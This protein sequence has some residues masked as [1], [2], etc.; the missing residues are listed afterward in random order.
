MAEPDTEAPAAAKAPSA[1]S[2]AVAFWRERL[3]GAA[4]TP[5]EAT[6]S[7]GHRAR[8][9]ELLAPVI[10]IL[11]PGAKA[12][13]PQSCPFSDRQSLRSALGRLDDI[14]GVDPEHSNELLLRL[15]VYG[16]KSFG[17]RLPEA[18]DTVLRLPREVPL[19]TPQE[20]VGLTGLARLERALAA[21]FV[22]PEALSA[23]G[24]AG[25]VL[26]AA[27][28]F[29]GLLRK[30]L[31]SG[32]LRCR[33][34]DL[35]ITPY[36]T[37]LAVPIGAE[38]ADGTVLPSHE[39][40]L[41]RPETELV[42]LRYWQ[43]D[44]QP[45][46]LGKTTPWSALKAYFGA[47]SVPREQ[48]PRSLTELNRWVRTRQALVL[49]PFLRE[50]LTGRFRCHGLGDVAHR[51][52]CTGEALWQSS[53][54]TPSRRTGTNQPITQ[55]PTP[56]GVTTL[57]AASRSL[58]HLLRQLQDGAGSR[59]E[60]RE[61]LARGLDAE[62]EQLGP[63]GWL[64][65]QW[66]VRLLREGR[67]ALRLSSVLRYVR[68]VKRYVLPQIAG[69]D[70]SSLT[71]DAW[72][73]RIQEAID[74]A[75]DTLAPVAIYWFAQFLIAQ[76]NGPGFDPDEIEG[77][78]V[79]SGVSANLISVADFE[80]AMD[81]LQMGSQR[82]T[83]M[84]RLVA[85]LGFYAGLRRGEALHIRMGDLSGTKSPWLFVR[86]NPHHNLKRV[87]SQRAL[88]LDALLPEPWLMRLRRW[89]E[90]R[91][92]EGRSTS[93][94]RLL[95]CAAGQDFDPPRGEALITPIRD[96]LR[97][98]TR[99]HSLV[100]HHLRHS[101]PNWTLIRLLAPELPLAEWQQRFA[102]LN[103]P[104]FSASAC[105]ALRG[106]ILGHDVHDEPVRHAA[107]ALARLMG[108]AEVATTLR[109]YVHLAD[110]LAFG[111]QTHGRALAL[112]ED[113]V[114]ALL[115][116]G[117]PGAPV[118]GR[119]HRWRRLRKRAWD[120]S[121]GGLCPETVLE[122]ARR[123]TLGYDE[124]WAST[125]VAIRGA[126]PIAGPLS[127]RR[128]LQLAD[129][130]MLMTGLCGDRASIDELAELLNVPTEQVQRA[131]DTVRRLAA[132]TTKRRGNARFTLPPRSPSGEADG[133]AWQRVLRYLAAHPLDRKVVAAGIGLLLRA[134]PGR[135][136]RVMLWRDED[137]LRFA[138][139]LR[140]LGFARS[141]LHVD[142]YP[143]PNQEEANQAHWSHLLGVQPAQ[144][145]VR[146]GK[147]V[148]P[149]AVHG[150]IAL[151][152]P[153]ERGYSRLAAANKP[154]HAFDARQAQRG[155]VLLRTAFA[156]PAWEWRVPD[157]GALD[158]LA[159]LLGWFGVPGP[160]ISANTESLRVAIAGVSGLS[161][162]TVE[163]GMQALA[164]A[165]AHH[166]LRLVDRDEDG[167]V[168]AA[169]V[170]RSWGVSAERLRIEHAGGWETEA[171]EASARRVA[172]RL[173]LD[174][175]QIVVKSRQ[176]KAPTVSLTVAL[177]RGKQLVKS[178]SLTY[179]LIM[180]YLL[181]QSLPV[182]S[183]EPE[184]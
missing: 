104:W 166:D 101:F 131:K 61:R 28:V 32:L 44:P 183:D 125:P 81:R 74:L 1:L 23:L 26:Y 6:G 143:Q 78:E 50:T 120:A 60:K 141:A 55:Q 46:S 172:E 144:I 15:V 170:L 102:A 148:G 92:A 84:V 161:T 35:A 72:L 40:W 11:Y 56:S 160:L 100:F 89:Y 99:D 167:I 96:A 77:V 90:R 114:R 64:I 130:P 42:L 86:G 181:D 3:F 178:W 13:V 52:F 106:A 65:G 17:W 37:W 59:A 18:I 176:G 112:G 54:E 80:A 179:A 105:S 123:G 2:L 108:H 94:D 182:A 83:E 158:D 152:V 66:C 147:R 30:D 39:R 71:D 122:F 48:Q 98:V 58:T 116:L 165:K 68:P 154:A 107:Y 76:P 173:Q 171:R 134:D 151:D 91:Q 111:H 82:D 177:D 139:L 184:G 49:P 38:T 97:A 129:M 109:H 153:A 137:V 57:S 24:R 175:S 27:I 136:H 22:Y 155:L 7:S 14:V 16:K 25:Q 34:E 20:I 12:K 140:S 110:L 29:G 87:A 62:A 126:P 41:V 169:Q 128:D 149:S 133:D 124:A 180:V 70:P 75:S 9:M 63:L 163:R 5:A 117:V 150:E 69:L 146:G 51:R 103:G 121:I 4:E 132:S 159:A 31:Q 157:A 43:D 85:V 118:D 73:G 164:D 162:Q 53:P 135:A 115:G 95:F 145:V 138:D 142:L 67:G 19:I 45:A 93:K 168:P 119:Y 21:S 36:G 156:G 8:H 10:R 79:A 113:Q 47:A 33:R 88:P 127:A 174:R